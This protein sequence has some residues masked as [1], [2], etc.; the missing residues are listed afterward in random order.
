MVVTLIE[1]S[2]PKAQA[3]LLIKTTKKP[4]KKALEDLDVGALKR[5]GCR[6]VETG[7][8]IVI[9]PADSEVDKIVTALLADAIDEQEA[10]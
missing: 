10:K 1:K 2:F 6:V 3:D 7:D 8:E 9:K 5:I 4:I